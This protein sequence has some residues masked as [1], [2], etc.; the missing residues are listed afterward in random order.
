MKM[1]DLHQI[2]QGWWAQAISTAA[3]VYILWD[4]SDT[5]RQQTREAWRNVQ[6]HWAH[7]KWAALTWSWRPVVRR[8]VREILEQD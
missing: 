2:L 3:T 7:L 5:F 4:L 6:E 1:S 8:Q